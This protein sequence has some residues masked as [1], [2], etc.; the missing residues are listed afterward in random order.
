MET[1][2]SE[3][4]IDFSNIV[5]KRMELDNLINELKKQGKGKEVIK[6]PS[7]TLEEIEEAE[8]KQMQMHDQLPPVIYTPQYPIRDKGQIE[9][10][11]PVKHIPQYPQPIIFPHYPN[12]EIITN[13]PSTG[14]QTDKDN[15]QFATQTNE[16]PPETKVNIRKTPIIDV[17]LPSLDRS[18]YLNA[19]SEKPAT[20]ILLREPFI[21]RKSINTYREY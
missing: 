21:I 6:Q 4:K 17:S 15:D 3:L 13:T 12:P 14:T 10:I 8:R 5:E 18:L 7:P 9:R 11:P 20:H 1:M 16:I 19:P 2:Q